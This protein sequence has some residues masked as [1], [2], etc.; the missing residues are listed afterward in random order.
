MAYFISEL[1]S[2]QMLQ[3]IV[4]FKKKMKRNDDDIRTLEFMNSSNCC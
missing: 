4:D 1:S 2:Y 3:G